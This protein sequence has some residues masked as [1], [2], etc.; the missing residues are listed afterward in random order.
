MHSR[1]KDIEEPMAHLNVETKIIDEEED[2]HARSNYRWLRSKKV[3]YFA[4]MVGLLLIVGVRLNFIKTYGAV[5]SDKLNAKN[6]NLGY[7][8]KRGNVNKDN[9]ITKEAHV[10]AVLKRLKEFAAES[11]PPKM[12]VGKG[13]NGKYIRLYGA[14]VGE[15]S[16]HIFTLANGI[17]VADSL[18]EYFKYGQL[19]YDGSNKEYARYTLLVPAYIT[20]DLQPFTLKTLQELYCV[21]FLQDGGADDIATR[22]FLALHEQRKTS[23]KLALSGASSLRIWL[24]KQI[25]DFSRFVLRHTGGQYVTHNEANMIANPP[26]QP[27]DVLISASNL[28]YWGKEV[29][30]SV[31]QEQE[32]LAD[33][34]IN[35]HAINSLNLN[36]QQTRRRLEALLSQSKSDGK[37]NEVTPKKKGKSIAQDDDTPEN[38]DDKR[39]GSDDNADDSFES[40]DTREPKY[41]R[42]YLR[43]NNYKSIMRGYTYGSDFIF[44]V[45]SDLTVLHE[46]QISSGEYVLGD[47]KRKAEKS[48][49][50]VHVL[51]PGH[52]AHYYMGVLSALWADVRESYKTF[53]LEQAQSLFGG[54]FEYS[55]VHKRSF[56]GTCHK[57]YAEKTNVERDFLPLIAHQSM[58]DS[59]VNDMHYMHPLCSMDPKWI[60]PLIQR[61]R[62]FVS[63]DIYVLTDGQTDDTLWAA[64]AAASGTPMQVANSTGLVNPNVVIGGNSFIDKRQDSEGLNA[65][66]SD[67][68]MAVLGRGI[69]IG[70][71]RSTFSFQIFILRAIL[72]NVVNLPL[73]MDFDL[74][75]NIN[76]DKHWKAKGLNGNKKGSKMDR[77]GSI[78]GKTFVTRN[79]IKSVKSQLTGVFD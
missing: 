50:P 40:D 61:K 68:W 75:F 69:F 17:A 27:G 46:S 23:L 22:D 43:E 36:L 3:L 51:D 24:H 18:S 11:A 1:K 53:A 14:G 79:I 12:Q 56:E 31:N 8:S 34:D 4:V 15:S 55:V 26:V 25:S 64:R 35:P 78:L 58:V 20:K 2:H 37:G 47:K 63:A 7:L 54:E 70:S 28:F 29:S 77:H 59:I 62:K 76:V 60:V 45:Q 5:K 39:D 48:V 44:T 38:D 41:W 57:E 73:A 32:A 10:A 9:A 71:P 30:T 16:N 52:F 6:V 67:L 65:V 21:Q 42:S 13:C 33:A 49:S 19:E 72:G 74:Y 66:M